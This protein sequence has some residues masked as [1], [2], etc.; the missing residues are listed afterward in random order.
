VSTASFVTGPRPDEPS[1]EIAV[2]R[3]MDARNPS[4]SSSPPKRMPAI[5]FAYSI[6]CVGT[7]SPTNGTKAT[8][9]VPG[10]VGTCE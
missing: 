4:S 1:P 8:I 2:L 7:S 5:V 6:V 3:V 9:T 10:P